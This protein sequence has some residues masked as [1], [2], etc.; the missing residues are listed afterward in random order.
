MAVAVADPRIIEV[1]AEAEAEAGEEEVEEE[2]GLE[3]T[4][5]IVMTVEEETKADLIPPNTLATIART[6]LEPGKEQLLHHQ[7]KKMESLV[8]RHTPSLRNI[9]FS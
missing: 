1:A 7:P 3:T 6:L 2:V 9:V 8:R 5:R 4:H